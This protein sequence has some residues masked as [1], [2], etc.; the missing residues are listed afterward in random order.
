MLIGSGNALSMGGY[1]IS[2]REQGP[3]SG[4]ARMLCALRILLASILLAASAAAQAENTFPIANTSGRET[5]FGAAFDGTN[6]LVGIQCDAASDHNITAQLVS[7]TGAL[8]GSRISTGA[9]GGVPRV[10]FDGTN[11][12][13]AWECD[14]SPTTCIAGQLVSTSGALVGSQFTIATGTKIELG[15]PGLV[16]DG[17]NYFVAWRDI[18]STAGATNTSELLGQFITTSGAKLGSAVSISTASYEVVR[19]IVAIAFDGAN[20]LAIWADG[21][22]QKACWS[23][24]R[25]RYCYETDIYGQFIAKSNASAAGTLSGSNFLIDAG[26]LQRDSPGGLSFDGTNY[27]LTFVEATA[28]PCSSCSWDGYGTAYGILVTKAGS[29]VSPKF[30]IGDTRTSNKRLVASNYLGAEYLVT[31]TDGAPTASSSVKGQYVTSTGVLDG[32]ELTLFSTSSG[33]V[34]GFC[35]A[36]TGGG[37]NLAITSWS[38]SGATGADVTGSILTSSGSDTS[39]PSVP[40][41]LS[42]TAASSTQINLSWTASTD[43]VGVTG[44][45]VYRN[46][47]LAGSPA[48][49]SY[50]DTGLSAST[51]YSYTVAACDAANNC[52]PQS[53]SVSAM[54]QSSV[55][56]LS[57]VSGW[58]L[59]GNSVQATIYVADYFND[60]AKVASVWKW[61]TTGTTS[62]VAYPTWAY[63]SP[64][65]SDRGQAYASGKGYELLTSINA[66][67]GFWVHANTAFTAQLPTGTSVASTSFRNMGSGWRLIATGSTQTPGSFNTDMS[68]TQPA[69]GVVPLNIKSLWAWDSAQSKWY[70]YAPGLEAKGGSALADY[71]SESGYLDFTTASKTL[72]SGI[73]FWVNMP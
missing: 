61:V 30:A 1:N 28:N 32:A 18:R 15:F 22:N 43:N 69:A 36:F 72:G 4:V 45:K 8:V 26:M 10:A 27:L 48:V 21:R 54:T 42:A 9:T 49:T 67:E 12:L 62:G 19:P 33:A 38:S 34:P 66:G 31:W 23:G 35:V 64:G 70:F 16:F 11:Y 52:S 57:L 44:Y 14:E 55:A 2:A 63:Y 17:T 50:S 29:A 65:Q 68:P 71:I 20:I 5:G 46:S 7:K 47:T 59:T 6:F 51:S 40:T 58:N 37:V 25:D 39:S 41:G 53:S 60:A 24:T 3:D 73:G 56:T 13:L